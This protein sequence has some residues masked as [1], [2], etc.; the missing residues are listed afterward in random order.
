MTHFTSLLIF[1]LSAPQASNR[2]PQRNKTSVSQEIHVLILLSLYAQ[3]TLV[4]Q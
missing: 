4:P 1:D 3:D 2:Q